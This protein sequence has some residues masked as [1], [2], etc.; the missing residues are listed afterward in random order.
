MT[1]NE[2]NK[3][4]ARVM[5]IVH[6]SLGTHIPY[7]CTQKGVVHSQGEDPAFH[8]ETVREYAEAIFLLTLVMEPKKPEG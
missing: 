4:L 3:H 6:D 7:C 8:V 2:R 5:H 1:K